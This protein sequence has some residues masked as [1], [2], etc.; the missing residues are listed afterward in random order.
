MKKIKTILFLFAI[1]FSAVSCNEDNTPQTTLKTIEREQIFGWWYPTTDN[2]GARSKAYYFG[3]DGQYQ[4][5][6]TNFGLTIGTGTWEWVAETNTIKMTPTAGGGINGGVQNFE[7][8]ELTADD[9]LLT[10]QGQPVYLDR[11]E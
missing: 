4:Q 3:E 5:D 1:A 9:F 10:M 11:N 8:L 7:V 6:M 2:D